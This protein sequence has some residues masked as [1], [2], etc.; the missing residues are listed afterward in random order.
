MVLQKEDKTN[1]NI[2]GLKNP[3]DLYVPQNRGKRVSPG[4]VQ[5]NTIQYFVKPSYYLNE[6]FLI[7]NHRIN[8][9]HDRDVVFVKLLP[10]L[11]TYSQLRVYVRY[12]DF[13]TP[14]EHNIS[15]VLPNC[16]NLGKDKI[17]VTCFK[18]PENYE[19]SFTAS[20]TGHVGVH[21]I[22][23]HYYVESTHD[24][25]PV[26]DVAVSR[27]RTKKSC[28][29]GSGRKKRSCVGTKPAP[30]PPTPSP[31]VLRPL[32]NASTDLK[33]NLSVNIGSCLYWS[34]EEW[35]D[36]GCKVRLLNAP[37]RCHQRSSL[38]CKTLK[39]QFQLSGSAVVVPM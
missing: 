34:G 23:I 11:S 27:E 5:S 24:V 18:D 6:T 31:I 12:S 14:T 3:I 37:I 17:D 38:L 22:G 9:P 4:T 16:E 19:F 26:S 33:Y 25:M 1:L 20:D 7:Q 2:T 39:F 10:E 30:L 21:Y 15:T 13:P 8:I 28:G 36:E 35:T 29:S 32:Y